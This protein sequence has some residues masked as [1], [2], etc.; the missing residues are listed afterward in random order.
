MAGQVG[1]RASLQWLIIFAVAAF[2][3]VLF[4]PNNRI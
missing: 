2:L 3:L 1:L 4:L